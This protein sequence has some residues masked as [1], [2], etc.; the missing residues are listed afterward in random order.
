MAEEIWG[1]LAKLRK[2]VKL[3][4][5]ASG[6]LRCLKEIGILCNRCERATRDGRSAALALQIA[7]EVRITRGQAKHARPDPDTFSGPGGCPRSTY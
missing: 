2:S 6:L 7:A 3:L 1:R 5:G 4:P